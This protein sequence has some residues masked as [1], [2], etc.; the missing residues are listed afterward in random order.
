[1][2]A[3]KIGERRAEDAVPCIKVYY[4]EQDEDVWSICKKYRLDRAKLFKNNSFEGGKAPR[5]KPVI[6]L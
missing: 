2:S 6:I 1:M 5:G 4:P 3:V